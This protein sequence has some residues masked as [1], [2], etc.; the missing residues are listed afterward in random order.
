MEAVG[1]AEIGTEGMTETG[2]EGTTETG[3]MRIAEI[4]AM[5]V[6]GVVARGIST[7]ATTSGPSKV[8]T[9]YRNRHTN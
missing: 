6:V 8:S 2:T 3:I 4:G 9:K 7:S 1:T 5:G